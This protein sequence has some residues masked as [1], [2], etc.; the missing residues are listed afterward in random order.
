[1][2]RRR[3]RAKA[4][5]SQ[6][7]AG[8][9]NPIVLDKSLPALPPSAVQQT[10]VREESPSDSYTDDHLKTG[11]GHGDM[12]PMSMS[13][14]S[15]RRHLS[16]T[17]A[18]S[19]AAQDG[20]TL[21][22]ST[23]KQ[24]RAS[25][26]SS[27]TIMSDADDGFLPMAYDPTPAPPPPIPR[28]SHPEGGPR[29]SD[30]LSPRAAFSAST[31]ERPSSSRSGSTERE[32]TRSPGPGPGYADKGRQQGMRN[33]SGSSTPASST[34][35]VLSPT[36]GNNQQRPRMSHSTSQSLA[37]A[38][39]EPFKLQQVPHDRRV[40]RNSPLLG[41]N[42]PSS[43]DTQT[44]SKHTPTN[45]NVSLSPTSV[46]T[47]S[48]SINP[49]DDPKLREASSSAAPSAA[50]HPARGDSLA[51]ATDKVQSSRVTSPE[52]TPTLRQAEN[53]HER[54]QSSASS[55]FVDA[56]IYHRHETDPSST[57]GMEIPSAPPRAANR[58]S[59]P[60]KSV[61]NA[62]FTAPRL[63]PAPPATERPRAESVDHVQND[64]NIATSPK[65][66]RTHLPKH[67]AGEA[68]TMEDEMARILRGDEHKR[69][70]NE[71][72]GSVLR[73][74][75]NAVK[76]GRSFSDKSIPL[77]QKTPTINSS[78]ISSPILISSPI[79]SP[80]QMDI[81][82]MRS[83]LRRAQQKISELEADK[84]NLEEK[85]ETSADIRQVN[86]ELRE[87]RSTMAFLDTQ[88]EMVIRE[89]EIMTEHLTKAKE[90]NKPL[91][92]S[93]LKSEVLQDFAHSMQRLKDSLGTQ[94]E[95]LV[96]KRN[97][98]TD[99]ITNLIQVKD[100]GLQEFESLS[101]K[102]TQLAELNNQLV[103]SIQEML[104][105][106][107]NKSA[108]FDRSALNSNGLGIYNGSSRGDLASIH[109]ATLQESS[110]LHDLLPH[111]GDAEPA[112]VLTAP[113]VVNIRKGQPKKFNWK[114]G[115]SGLAKNVTKGIKGAFA[116]NNDRGVPL[117]ADGSYDI[118]GIPYSQMQ[119]GPGAIMMGDQPL[120]TGDPKSFGFFSG[121]KNGLK[122]PS[123]QGS[124]GKSSATNLLAEP[125]SGKFL[126][127]QGSAC[128]TIM[129]TCL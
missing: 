66:W 55:Q 6:A 105:S 80:S 29:L 56:P 69:K 48:S 72:A 7:A 117:K 46:D 21:P 123:G 26:M 34:P 115:S 97:E 121:Q 101:S 44:R 3:K 87:K 27:S 25:A 83:Q 120:K 61:A 65:H 71:S 129:L 51:S 113:Q 70:E 76:H 78:D 95:D 107:N 31:R 13:D 109:S 16:H 38:P 67:S 104:K 90:S 28:R 40:S 127:S 73:R 125:P 41:K 42:S 99:D 24:K 33:V 36:P 88:R 57:S 93:Q 53:A 122:P 10:A 96:H 81:T 4:T 5:K 22:A 75:S 20:L 74:V 17:S 47:P 128:R 32:S 63:P 12:S 62:D 1:M 82:A 37:L 23:Y 98:L 92:I 91:D 2:A 11:G 106:H 111:A 54:K 102:N 35:T 84:L 124:L 19:E 79:S 85:M 8:S 14:D 30:N 60:G 52:S 86:T 116:G 100:K 18:L 64:H 94:I 9:S 114:K 50:K 126:L 58:P 108:S 68:F 43:L 77:Q 59:A 89:L 103:S 39:P 119:T 112:H 49:F 110:S 118:T 45:S 15:N